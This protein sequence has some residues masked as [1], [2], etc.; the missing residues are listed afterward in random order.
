MQKYQKKS[1]NNTKQNNWLSQEKFHFK[2]NLRFVARPVLVQA[3]LLEI[4]LLHTKSVRPC[5]AA[6]RIET[7]LP[8]DINLSNC[9][10]AVATPW[11]LM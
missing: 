6:P 2:K 9:D 11:A 10:I 3:T 1:L 4:G 8:N 5:V 7:C